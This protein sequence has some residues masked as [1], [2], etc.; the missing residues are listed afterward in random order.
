[1]RR[2]GRKTLLVILCTLF[3]IGSQEKVYG[4]VF[5]T[6]ATGSQFLYNVTTVVLNASNS[7]GNFA[8]PGVTDG[9]SGVGNFN[10]SVAGVG[11]HVVH[12]IKLGGGA[13]DDKLVFKYHNFFYRIDCNLS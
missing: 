6:P 7:S 13:Y 5:F 3:V 10:P 2:K 1:M 8:G 4:Q 12:Y 9:G 11:S